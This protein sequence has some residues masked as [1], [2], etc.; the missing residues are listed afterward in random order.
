MNNTTGD[1]LS[2]LI[3]HNKE[4][5]WL[6]VTFG[7]YIT[8]LILGFVGNVS[9][10]FVIGVK[11]TRK[12][13]PHE[14]FIL[15]LAVCD[16]MLIMVFIP[17][18]IYIFMAKFTPSV[19]YCKLIAPLISVAFGASVFTLTVM[20]VHRCYVITNPFKLDISQRTVIIWL[21]LIWI[22]SL[23]LVVPKI[24]VSTQQ[25]SRCVQQWPSANFKKFYTLSLFIARFVIPLFVITYAYVRIVK[26]LSGST[27][28]RFG[29]DED[30]EIKTRTAKSENIT[31]VK[32]LAV[33][34]V[35]F[36]MCMLPYRLATI[37]MMF[38]DQHH[39]R[40]ARYVRQYTSVLTIFHSCANPI[41]YGTLTKQFRF[42]FGARC[43]HRSSSWFP[44][45]SA[46][47][48]KNLE[49]TVNI[50]NRSLS[51]K[52]EKT[53]EFFTSVKIKLE[54]ESFKRNMQ[55]KETVV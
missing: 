31:V 10:L 47:K 21:V 9:V 3:V 46:H 37:I 34:V 5:L 43:I 6:K 45:R 30:G 40:L 27:A 38:G 15:N 36:V 49:N 4:H 44:C 14:L 7:L 51:R 32:T 20:A 18:Q 53:P 13:R 19:F 11:K 2:S 54:P 8:T 26:D 35:L 24:H 41:A 1:V 12:W 39:A 23:G 42:F 17:F 48:A 16:L 28:P 25:S 33:I 22:L 29:L 55:I 52:A 50:V